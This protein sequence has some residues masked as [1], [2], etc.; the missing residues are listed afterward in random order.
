MYNKMTGKQKTR[1]DTLL[2]QLLFQKLK[3]TLR[4]LR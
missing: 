4:P 1:W 2:M 3:G